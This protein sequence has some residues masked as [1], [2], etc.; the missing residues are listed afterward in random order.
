MPVLLQLD[1]MMEGKCLLQS[2][3]VVTDNSVYTKSVLGAKLTQ[4][5]LKIAVK[6]A[7]QK[8]L[9][10]IHNDISTLISPWQTYKFR[11]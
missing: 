2:A 5:Q 1:F 8:S 9:M 11:Q 3:G 10:M 4:Y 7:T 6:S